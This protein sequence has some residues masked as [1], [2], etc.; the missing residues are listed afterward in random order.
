M[1]INIPLMPDQVDQTQQTS[2]AAQSAGK[3]IKL[4]VLAIA[5][6]LGPLLVF[7]VGDRLRHCPQNVE[8]PS[9][10]RSY[11]FTLRASE[12]MDT[13]VFSEP[14]WHLAASQHLISSWKL[15]RLKFLQMSDQASDAFDPDLSRYRH[16]IVVATIRGPPP[17]RRHE[18][19]P[20]M[21]APHQGIIAQALPLAA[22]NRAAIGLE[23]ALGRRLFPFTLEVADLPG[24]TQPLSPPFATY[25]VSSGRIILEAAVVRQ[26]TQ[27]THLAEGVSVFA[28]ALFLQ[29]S[30]FTFLRGPTDLKQVAQMVVSAAVSAIGVAIAYQVPLWFCIACPVVLGMLAPFVVN[31]GLALLASAACSHWQLPA[32]ECNDLWY[33][34]F[35]AGMVLSLASAIPI[36]FICKLPQC[37][38]RQQT[39]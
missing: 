24:K 17:K 27:L 25:D 9:P 4:A 10:A 21:A 36:V 8:P 37:A 39:P 16:A 32:E 15:G 1:S 5:G 13:A 26:M 14:A 22:I 11:N 19:Q 31:G 20:Y 34:V 23:M 2:H 6:F 30:R 18:M 7:V 33:G 28:E 3:W 29:M 12:A 35:A 38:H